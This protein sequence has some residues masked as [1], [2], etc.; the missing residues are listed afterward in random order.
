METEV[1]YCKMC[2]KALPPLSDREYCYACEELLLFDKVREFVRN[3]DVNEYQVAEYFDIPVRMVK[4]WIKEG[5][6]EYKEKDKAGIMSN[7]CSRCGQPVSFGTLC[8]Q[9]L[10][11]LNGE[12]DWLLKTGRRGIGRDAFLRR[13][14]KVSSTAL[15]FGYICKTE[16]ACDFHDVS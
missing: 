15:I 8:P 11:L 9:C 12:N 16:T 14:K 6:I 3:N 5:R 13:R 1:K 4:Q 10:R 2:R 7:Y